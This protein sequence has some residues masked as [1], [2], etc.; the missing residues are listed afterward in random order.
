[1]TRL[2]CDEDGLYDPASF[3][4]RLLLGLKGTLALRFPQPHQVLDRHPPDGGRAPQ[5]RAAGTS[6]QPQAA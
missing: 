6:A 5:A 1:M 3:N 2:I 4:D